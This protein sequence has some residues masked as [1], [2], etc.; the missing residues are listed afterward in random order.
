MSYIATVDLG[1][2][3]QHI[4]RLRT[5]EHPRQRLSNRPNL[6]R[7]DRPGSLAVGAKRPLVDSSKRSEF[8]DR[9]AYHLRANRFPLT[10]SQVHRLRIGEQNAF[11]LLF[12]QVRFLADME[13]AEQLDGEP[14]KQPD[15]FL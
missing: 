10:T 11:L 6:V 13:D 12:D 7:R 14:T 15:C 1:F 4:G 5:T 8:P 3:P 9:Y 2:E